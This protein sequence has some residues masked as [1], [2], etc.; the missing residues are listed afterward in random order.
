MARRIG[1]HLRQFSPV[2]V[3]AGLLVACGGS[4]YLPAGPVTDPASALETLGRFR[5]PALAESWTSYSTLF[6]GKILAAQ[7]GLVY[8]F[9]DGDANRDGT[10]VELSPQNGWAARTLIEDEVF[11]LWEGAD[12]L[13]AAIAWQGSPWEIA[14]LDKTTGRELWRIQTPVWPYVLREGTFSSGSLRLA[15]LAGQERSDGTFVLVGAVGMWAGGGTNAAIELDGATGELTGGGT[16]PLRMDLGVDSELWIETAPEGRTPSGRIVQPST[17]DVLAELPIDPAD[18]AL[19]EDS[20]SGPPGFGA[21]MPYVPSVAGQDFV[22]GEA[23]TARRFGDTLFVVS[24]TTP[25]D[26]AQPSTS[27]TI[28][29]DVA[30]GTKVADSVSGAVVSFQHPCRA[31]LPSWDDICF[32]AFDHRFGGDIR[33][34]AI[35]DLQAR[36][37]RVIDAPL[38]P[39]VT[40]PFESSAIDLAGASGAAPDA[41]RLAFV[42]SDDSA[43]L[44]SPAAGDLR[45]LGPTGTF[46]DGE[47]LLPRIAVL[48]GSVLVA[49]PDALRLYDAR[50]ASPVDSLA[51]PCPGVLLRTHPDGALILTTGHTDSANQGALCSVSILANGTLVRKDETPPAPIDSLGEVELVAVDPPGGRA[52]L[53][54][55][56][57][58]SCRLF[59]YDLATG[60]VTFDQPLIGIASGDLPIPGEI[61]LVHAAGTNASFLIARTG[62][63]AAGVF[64]VR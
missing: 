2:L 50:D 32:L 62:S 54:G 15:P 48:G 55:C 20:Q 17:A 1:S 4:T 9:H 40:I 38:P 19:T 23:F 12:R 24:T 5:H 13:Y 8:W 44:W 47:D 33:G 35:L 51:R 45:P 36:T 41:L 63:D 3:L 43:Y 59:G 58:R 29:Y 16:V 34:I 49:E 37:W 57:R 56:D 61:Q 21:R 11:D 39:G 52:V 30:S 18:Y 46:H 6:T 14:A 28:A 7:S 42:A 10:V 64:C 53:T 31:G 25:G 27:R 26:D 22:F 60:A